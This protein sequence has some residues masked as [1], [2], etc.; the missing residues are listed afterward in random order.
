[1]TDDGNPFNDDIQD[2]AD[3]AA[4]ELHL[5]KITDSDEL[6]RA[7]GAADVLSLLRKLG[8]WV[9][10]GRRGDRPERAF[11]HDLAEL[12]PTELGNESGYWQS[13]LSR[14]IAVLGA[15]SGAERRL[16]HKIKR[17]RDQEAVRLLREAA[18]KGEKAPTKAVLDIKVSEHTSVVQLENQLGVLESVSIAL[19]AAREAIEGY[20]RV[21]SRELTR[22]GDMLRAGI[23]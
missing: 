14:V 3:E 9:G 1:M 13:E 21:L 2:A 5:E 22:R 6:L 8:F 23:G 4:G 18:D 19:S 7:A 16:K 12:T 20:C 15:L 17:A 10:D 11:R